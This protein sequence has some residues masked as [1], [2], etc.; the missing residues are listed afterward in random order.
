[1]I[2]LKYSKIPLIL[3]AGFLL[4]F[5]GCTSVKTTGKIKKFDMEE[6]SV[7]VLPFYISNA[8]W[9]TEFADAV[10]FHLRDTG[11]F[12]IVERQQ[13]SAIIKEQSISQSGMISDKDRL[14]I[15]RIHGVQYL[16][17]GRGTAFT[18]STKDK[19][20]ADKLVDTFT[21]NMVDTETG[22]VVLSARKTEGRAWTGEYRA[23]YILSGSL[24]WDKEDIL[25]EST[26]YDNLAETLTDYIMSR[27][28]WPQ[29]KK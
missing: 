16:I 28:E 13:L 21:L 14:S 15:G 2:K 22:E 10:A 5:S 8:K 9:G 4:S 6:I 20:K 1:M 3:I 11:K 18:V 19:K 27:I 12:R 17:M 25:V 29:Q 23:K 24:I 26:T 7:A